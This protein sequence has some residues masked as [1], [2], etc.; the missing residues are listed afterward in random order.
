MKIGNFDTAFRVMIIAEI[1]N[2]HEGSEVVAGEMIDAA[3]AIGVD[4]VKFQTF[5][6]EHYVSQN[7]ADRYSRLR[8]FQLDYDQFSRLADRAKS[9]GLIFLSTP[10]DIGSVRALEPLV[11]AFKIASGDN[12]FYP[13]L[14]AVADTHKPVLLSTGFAD[15]EI[16]RTAKELFQ[17]CWGEQ[18]VNDQLALLHCVSNY[19]TSPEEANL[20]AIATMQREI[21]CTVGY[22]DHTIGVDA[23]VLSVAIGARIIEKH[24]TLDKNYSDFRDHAISADPEDMAELVQSIRQAETLLGT[25]EKK[26][27]ESEVA[28]AQLNRR[29]IVAARDLKAGAKLKL[30]DITWVRPG[31]GLSPGREKEILNRSLKKNVPRGTLLTLV[32]VE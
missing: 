26:P 28:T 27:S 25:G 18:P 4:A 5:R 2:N 12:T 24:F 20:S 13:L 9:H 14:E 16:V 30:T 10:F 22:S 21:G 15:L 6:A 8:R 11:P 23:A 17:R 29:S 3:A 31:T 1:G 7:D 32:H 19:P